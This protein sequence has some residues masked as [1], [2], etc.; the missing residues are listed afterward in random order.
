LAYI[1]DDFIPATIYSHWG[2]TDLDVAFG[3]LPAWITSEELNDFDIVTYGFGDQHRLYLRGQFTFHKNNPSV[4]NIWRQCN[5]LSQLDRRNDFKLQSAEGCYSHMVLKSTNLKVKF[6]TKALSDVKEAQEPNQQ[7]VLDM[8]GMILLRGRH[9]SIVFQPTTRLVNYGG[10][11]DLR[12]WFQKDRWENKTLQWEVGSLEPVQFNSNHF[13]C[14]YWVPRN[15]QSNLCATNVKS[16]DTIFLLNGFLFKRQYK[17]AYFPRGAKSKA[18]FHFQSWK[19]NYRSWQL[20][21]FRRNFLSIFNDGFEESQLGWILFPEGGLPLLSENS[22]DIN[23]VMNDNEV[24]VPSEGLLPKRTFCL[25]RIKNTSTYHCDRGLSWKQADDFKIFSN[26]DR[27]TKI[28]F[29]HSVTIVFT[30]HLK[31]TN[32]NDAKNLKSKFDSLEANIMSWGQDPVVV[33]LELNS[34]AELVL[35]LV[36]KKTVQILERGGPTLIGLLISNTPNFI[37]D[38]YSF[39]YIAEEAS[40]T[41]WTISGFELKDGIIL[42]KETSFFAKRAAMAYKNLPGN[43]FFIPHLDGRYYSSPNRTLDSILFLNEGKLEETSSFVRRDLKF[44]DYESLFKEMWWTMTR[45]EITM[46]KRI[47]DIALNHEIGVKIMDIMKD[48]LIQFTQ[49]EDLH[50]FLFGEE[51][52]GLMIDSFGPSFV[53]AHT[54]LPPMSD[55]SCQKCIR[56]IRIAQLSIIGYKILPL[57]AAFTTTL[58]TGNKP[59][60]KLQTDVVGLDRSLSPNLGRETRTLTKLAAM[61]I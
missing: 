9:K 21:P 61:L 48:L 19:R 25:K 45:R 58:H 56:V 52:M 28:N 60:H 12:A 29:N 16:A 10:N 30:L 27:S 33:L 54:I 37:S 24:F 55:L 39:S 36:I 44:Q 18:F 43:I 51:N 11:Y 46:R 49:T 26:Y 40:L 22:K 35:N 8:Y 5:H 59:D 1:F 6:A 3:D 20:A 53:P 13:N 32:I 34:T 50:V 38:S 2:Y 57:A 7:D 23:Q 14:M 47:N 17:E 31:E 4:N 42:S 15:Y 41:R